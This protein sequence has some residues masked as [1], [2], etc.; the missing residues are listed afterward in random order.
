[1]TKIETPE[2]FD[3]RIRDEIIDEWGEISSSGDAIPII[4]TRDA[5]IRADERQKAAERLLVDM[6]KWENLSELGAMS[7]DILAMWITKRI[8]TVIMI[9]SMGKEFQQVAE[10]EKAAYKRG[11]SDA[12]SSNYDRIN[13][14]LGL[15]KTAPEEAGK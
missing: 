9:E 3:Y 1:M 11:F 13:E 10:I 5:A 14:I 15:A 4:I 2:E 8:K 12:M 6:A 7:S